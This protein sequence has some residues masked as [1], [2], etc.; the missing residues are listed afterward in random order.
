MNGIVPPD[1]TSIRTLRKRKYKL[2]HFGRTEYFASKRAAVARQ[3]EVNHAMS[4]NANAISTLAGEVYTMYRSY[5]FRLDNKP[6]NMIN[7]AFTQFDRSLFLMVSRSHYEN[8]TT[9]T[10]KHYLDCCGYLES[11]LSKIQ[12]HDDTNRQTYAR[13]RVTEL[14][15]R[16]NYLRNQVNELLGTL[17]N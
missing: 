16:N 7:T 10:F 14:L 12:N 8:G 5:F 1:K 11:I 13:Q 3:F 2:Y 4:I 17:E 15:H 6:R 9:F